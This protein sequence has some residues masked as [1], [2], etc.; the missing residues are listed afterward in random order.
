MQIAST[1]VAYAALVSLAASG[2]ALC[3]VLITPGSHSQCKETKYPHGGYADSTHGS[4]SL[5][6][7]FHYIHITA[8]CAHSHS[9]SLIKSVYALRTRDV[10]QTASCAKST[11]R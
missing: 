10:A 3:K 2:V 9:Q 11:T 5:C 8:L 6:D 4:V 1:D 7:V